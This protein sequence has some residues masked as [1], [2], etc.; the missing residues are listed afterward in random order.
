[1]SW[2]TRA[3]CA[4]ASEQDELNRICRG[5]ACAVLGCAGCANFL[6]RIPKRDGRIGEPFEI[7]SRVLGNQFARGELIFRVI[8]G[9]H[10]YQFPATQVTR[11]EAA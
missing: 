1:M 9:V 10:C 11:T 8:H 5:G 6:N 4:D 3:G 2:L 7:G